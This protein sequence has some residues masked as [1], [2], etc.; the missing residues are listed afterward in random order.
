MQWAVQNWPITKNGILSLIAWF[1]KKFYFSIRTFCKELIW[2]TNYPN[3]H[4][5][6]FRKRWSFIWARSFPVSIL[7]HLWWGVFTK[8]VY[9]FYCSFIFVKSSIADIWQ[10]P[11]Y[12]SSFTRNW[13]SFLSSSNLIICLLENLICYSFFLRIE[14]YLEPTRTSTTELFCEN[15]ERFLTVNYFRK[16]PQS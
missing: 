13:W 3:V 16:K 15:S 4:I 8:I 7:K 2:C 11:K 12:A 1:F 5:H 6:P 14:V 9:G 10:V